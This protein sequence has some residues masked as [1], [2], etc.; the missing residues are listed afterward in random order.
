LASTSST[1]P[2]GRGFLTGQI[3][4]FEDLADDDYRRF[5]PPGQLA[6]AWVLAQGDDIV[7]IPGTKRRRYLDEN[8][9]ESAIALS[10]TDLT[11]LA[12]VAP[13]GVAAGDRYPATMMASVNR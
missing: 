11:R 8:A 6:L 4:R 7:P 1:P 13:P 2:T 9:A 10:K 3:K 5:S 12:A